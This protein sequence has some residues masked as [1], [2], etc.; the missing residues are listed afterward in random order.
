MSTKLECPL[1]GELADCELVDYGNTEYFNCPRCKLYQVTASAKMRLG[2]S[3][4]RNS[5]MLISRDCKEGT[6]LFIRT[7]ASHEVVW[8]VLPLAKLRH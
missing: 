1:C 2:P 3:A 7:N 8:E 5:L 4:V 6:G